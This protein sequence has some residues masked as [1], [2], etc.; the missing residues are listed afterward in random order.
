MSDFGEGFI[1][2]AST[3]RF[4]FNITSKHHLENVWNYNVFIST[5]D[6]LNSR[7]SVFPDLPIGVGGQYSDRFSDSLA[8]RSTLKSNLVNELR[9]GIGSGG[10]VLFFPETFAGAFAPLGG[11]NVS[12]GVFGPGGNTL[13]S[14]A[15]GSSSS[16]L[17]LLDRMSNQFR[18]WMLCDL[19]I[20][21]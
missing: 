8:L 7:D 11:F 5:P 4:D 19:I 1:S 12:F 15:S 13:S 20:P 9:V 10:T 18:A 21:G 6:Q 16:I 2:G 3:V 17:T 14:P